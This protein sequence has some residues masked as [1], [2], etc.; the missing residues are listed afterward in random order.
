MK[1][2]N[3]ILT[4]LA[5][6]LLI[7]CDKPKEKSPGELYEEAQIYLTDIEKNDP[8]K[9][10]DILNKVITLDPGSI[11][12]YLSR[13]DAYMSLGEN[14]KAFEDFNT[15]IQLN[16]DAPDIYLK[17]GEIYSDLKQYEKALKDFNHAIRLKPNF[18]NAY[19]ERGKIY[20]ATGVY[21]KALEDF[22]TALRIDPNHTKAGLYIDEV[23][24]LLLK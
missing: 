1:L 11:K 9:A 19:F 13:A 6:M 5:M 10:L 15:A 4:V 21:N 12:V 24:P 7:G 17:R 16:P 14:E 2:F 23:R 3:I 20:F 18:A 22:T 8:V